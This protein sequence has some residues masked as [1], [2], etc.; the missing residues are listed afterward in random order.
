MPWDDDSIRGP[1]GI[2]Y[3]MWI[4]RD[5][6]YVKKEAPKAPE[7]PKAPA[8][9]WIK[10]KVVDDQSGEVIPKVKLVIKTPDNS[11]EEHETRPSGLIESLGLQSGN[12]EV[13]CE[14]KE[15]TLEN[16]VSFV[17]VGEQ[18]IGKK[19]TEKSDSNNT[20]AK[21]Q[22]TKYIASVEEHKVKTGE[23]LKSIAASAGLSWQTLAKYNWGTDVPDEI[24][25]HLAHD[26]GCTK[27]TKDKKNYMFDDSDDPGIIYIPHPWTYQA[28]TNKVHTVR[29]NQIAPCFDEQL[30][31]VSEEG[32]ALSNIDYRLT[33]DNGN[34]VRGKTDNEGQTKRIKTSGAQGIQK[35]EFFAP[36]DIMLCHATKLE[37]GQAAKSVAVTDIATNQENVG[38]SVKKVTLENAARL[39]TAGE[40]AMARLIF[41]DSIDYSKVK[42]HKETYLPFGWQD[43]NTAMTPNGEMYFSPKRFNEDFSAGDDK[44]WF[45][46]EMTH[47]WQYRL[48]YS[49][50]WTGIKFFISGKYSDDSAYEYDQVRDIDKTLPDFNMEQQGDL[51]AHYFAARYLNDKT[52]IKRITF[53]EHVLVGFLRDP[54]NAALLPK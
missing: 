41:K 25:K 24:N 26:V 33:L 6:N 45:I 36:A 40:T 8:N 51:I 31:F 15:A 34:I 30:C 16:T 37:S 38:K 14:L 10:I 3:G 1:G 21:K 11:N 18:P 19:N 50:S 42:V 23:T 20:S 13:R 27:K 17:G 5:P 28:A 46:H 39:L 35:A 7:P 43:D 2:R 4:P 32:V 9:D 44:T 54:K 12:C 53:L 52:Y 47:V 48:G 29:V 49:V 22:G